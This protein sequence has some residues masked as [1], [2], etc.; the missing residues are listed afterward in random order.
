ML[1]RKTLNHTKIFTSYMYMNVSSHSNKRCYGSMVNDGIEYTYKKHK[2]NNRFNVNSSYIDICRQER[3]NTYD[4]GIIKHRLNDKLIHKAN[5]FRRDGVIFEKV[6]GIIY[7]NEGYNVKLTGGTNDAGVDLIV[8]KDNK[9]IAIQAKNYNDKMTAKY[10]N[11]KHIQDIYTKIKNDGEVKHL[12][13]GETFY[14]ARLHIYND[15]IVSMKPEYIEQ[16]AMTHGYDMFDKGIYGKT[17]LLNYINSLTSDS[18]SKF[19]ELLE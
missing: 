18:I 4:I 19:Y 9:K 2:W 1:V 6:L 7:E 16:L 11:K 12:V 15:N 10:L 17:W 8:E 13:Q 3:Q 5:G 14:S